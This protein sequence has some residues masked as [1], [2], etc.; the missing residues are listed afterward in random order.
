MAGRIQW[1]AQV[2]SNVAKLLGE[3]KELRNE[4]ETI[5]KKDIKLDID[6]KSLN[7]IVDLFGK[8][9]SHLK[10]LKKVFV[11]VGDGAE[12]SPLL[13]TINNIQSSIDKLSTSV[14]SIGFNMNI[15]FG[16]DTEMEAKI[17]SKI[18]N[19]LQAYQRLFD[20]IKMSGV[21]G[22]VINTN[23]FEFDINQYDTMMAKL[24]A[25][26]KFIETMRNEA[27]A[28]FSGKDVL[29]QG[30]DKSYWT[31]ASSA[32]GQVT[33]AFNEM[34]A[35]ADTSPLENLFGSKT[36][37]KEVVSQ[38]GLIVNKLEEISSVASK[39]A[40]VDVVT[41]PIKDTFQGDKINQATTSA[42]ELDK[43]LEQAFNIPS[44]DFDDVIAKFNIIE[45]K[46]R[47]IE[48]ITKSSVWNK[49]KNDGKGGYDESYTVKYKDGSSEIYGES[50]NPKL[51]RDNNVLYDAKQAE[52]F[53]KNLN[54]AHEEAI[55]V[56][57]ALNETK[58]KIDSLSKHP[59]LLIQFSEVETTISSL[60]AKL[61]QGEITV[62]E[63]NKA[64]KE[65]ASN[66]TK[67]VDIQ[68]KRDVEIYNADVKKASEDAKRKADDEAQALKEKSDAWDKNVK[69]IQE[70]MDANT[71]LNNL[72]AKDKGTGKNASEIAYQTEQ[73]EKL[74]KVALEARATLSS[75]INPHETPIDD[76]NKWLEAMKQFDQATEGSAKSVA[77]LE[78][79]L[80]NMAESQGKKVSSTLESSER[81]L[82]T[83]KP[84]EGN[85]SVTFEKN[86]QEYEK[87]VNA[88]REFH[89]TL[90]ATTPLTKE[91]SDKFEELA[92]D[93][94]NARI[95]IDKIP[96]A[97]RGS[98]ED[99]RTKEIDKLTK[100][101]DKN[102]RI[103]KEAKQQLQGYLDLLKSGDPSISVKELHTAWTKVAV[104]ERE[105]GREGKRFW[106]II[107]DKAVYGAA[108]Q[109]AGYYLSLTDF[110]RYGKE[111][112][113]V[114]RELD[115]ALTEMRKVSDETVSSL[116]RFQDVSFDLAN[117]VGTTAVQIQN[118]TADWM[119]LGE[120]IDDASKSAEVSNILL[121][122]SE[123]E[124][125]D[126]ATSSL[127]SMSQAYKDLEKIEIVDTLNKLGNEYAIS[128][129][130]LA[131]ALK[132]SASALKTAQ[133]DFYEASALTTAANT[134]VQDPAKVGA[135]LRTIAL[136]LTGTEAAREELE[137]LGEDV[138]DFQVTTTSKL[139][140]QIMDLTKTQDGLS[141]SLLD[142]NGNYRSTYDVLLDIAKIWDKIAEE[143]LVTGENRQ[144][145]LLEMMAGKNRSNILASILESPEIL[146]SAYTDAINATGS[147]QEELDKY[148]ESIDGRMAKLSNQAQEFWY[149]LID[150][151]TIKNGITLLT[152]LLGLAT[153]FVDTFG[154]LGT[155]GI[156]GGG[157]LG[158]KN[159]G[160]PKMFGLVLK[161]AD[162]YKCSLGY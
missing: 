123:F 88:L 114:I 141:V 59:E 133:N 103:S 107:T 65:T 83:L 85:R 156:I 117:N 119:R 79:A 86:V 144:N 54:Q 35:S 73:V 70:Y 90:D 150:S 67:L 95:E 2:D 26:R 28:Q 129:D 137:Q 115:T 89:A 152:D 138:S 3:T 158:A 155:A 136:R 68:Q 55:K 160:R 84:S 19:A 52:N 39:L 7:S 130:G 105:A 13:K 154:A 11:D 126:E 122:V 157:I 140:Q 131:T 159:I 147:A 36:D 127:V 44:S 151:D 96:K 48:K 12:F 116:E 135:G 58:V 16:S 145:A 149:K 113:Q 61:I 100:Y 104:A 60:N 87:A 81:F 146:E 71:E 30:T 92:K 47:N 77:K 45:E 132:D 134:V 20:H 27:K 38:L 32:M 106:D 80:R 143:D 69:A 4:L 120:A 25:Y 148:L 111:G 34:N 97:L 23:F 82:A 162:N 153:D 94:K 40:K 98:D 51:L 128:T 49:S 31:A 41:A 62:S 74:E 63:Y 15:D 64:V 78:D 14:K 112:I 57:N 10:D 46:A 142:M 21:G 5:S 118:S 33:K 43:T 9:E 99:G 93:V 42:R 50:S 124:S 8:M 72:K 29:F 125:I 18:S 1:E 101:L 109:L 53:Q 56:N 110:I 75:M 121:N 66:Y 102:T 161:Y 24:Q 37:L 139:N 22:S 76:W 108:A 17:Q 6:S 91:Q